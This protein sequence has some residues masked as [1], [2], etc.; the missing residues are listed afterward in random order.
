[1]PANWAETE[2]KLFNLG[3]KPSSDKTP[4]SGDRRKAGSGAHYTGPERRQ[5]ADR[6]GL[7]YGLKFKTERAVGPIEEWLDRY[8]ADQHRLTIEGMSDDLTIKDVRVVFATEEQR[9]TFKA[10][11]SIYIQTAEFI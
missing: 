8:M 4:R 3:G 6:R 2:M 7:G 11:L 9:A 10:A 1:M 5:G